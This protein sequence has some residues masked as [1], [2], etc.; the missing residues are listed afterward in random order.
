MVLRIFWIRHNLCTLAISDNKHIQF[1]FFKKKT[2]IRNTY[3]R[4]LKVK[5][6]EYNSKALC[7]GLGCNLF[8]KNGWCF[9][10]ATRVLARG[11]CAD[12]WIKILWNHLYSLFARMSF[13]CFW[14]F[15]GQCHGHIVRLTW[16]H[17]IT[18]S[19]T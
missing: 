3:R 1:F 9:I 11:F 4:S 13:F 5:F 6:V 8:P 12:T 7:P 19:L 17:H 10:S 18:W 2:F 15:D 14:A 16:F